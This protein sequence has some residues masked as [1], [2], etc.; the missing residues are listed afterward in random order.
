MFNFFGKGKDDRRG[1]HA[2]SQAPP[3][4]ARNSG[5]VFDVHRLYEEALGN[6]DLQDFETPRPVGLPYEEGGLGGFNDGGPG[7]AQP[8]PLQHQPS[9][10]GAMYPVS[11]RF[12]EFGEKM[13]ARGQSRKSVAMVPSDGLP[14]DRPRKSVVGFQFHTGGGEEGRRSSSKRQSLRRMGSSMGVASGTH[15][16]PAIPFAP[17]RPALSNP[18]LRLDLSRVTGSNPSTSTTNLAPPSP[19]EP[20]ASSSSGYPLATMGPP[21]EPEFDYQQMSDDPFE[22]AYYAEGG[23]ASHHPGA[24]AGGGRETARGDKDKKRGSL[25]KKKKK[26]YLYCSQKTDPTERYSSFGA[27]RDL[28]RVVVPNVLGL[29]LGVLPMLMN[30]VGVWIVGGAWDVSI[31][32]LSTVIANVCLQAPTVGMAASLG[33]LVPQAL[34]AHSLPLCALWLRR[35]LLLLLVLFLPLSICTLK[36]GALVESRLSSGVPVSLVCLRWLIPACL[37]T[38]AADAI[39]GAT[40]AVGAAGPGLLGSLVAAVAHGG[41]LFAFL[42]G[43]AGKHVVEDPSARGAAATAA[44]VATFV[45]S[46]FQLLLLVLLSR[47]STRARAVVWGKRDETS[48]LSRD[49]LRKWG[50][51]IRVGLPLALT[52]VVECL[53]FELQTLEVLWL[54]HSGEAAEEVLL[55]TALRCCFFALHVVP[56]GL[57]LATSTLA[58]SAVGFGDGVLARV[59]VKVA[60]TMI[61]G[62][63]VCAS[64]V[65]MIFGFPLL[66]LLGAHEALRGHYALPAFALFEVVCAVTVIQQSALRAAGRIH[67][68]MAGTVLGFYLCTQPL[69]FV[70]GLACGFPGTAAVWWATLA[71]ACV[72]FGFYLLMLQRLDW[73]ACADAA[74]EEVQQ[75]RQLAAAEEEEREKEAAERQKQGADATAAANGG[76]RKPTAASAAGLTSHREPLLSEDID[77]RPPTARTNQLQKRQT[78]AFEEMVGVEEEDED[79]ESEEGAGGGEEGPFSFRPPN[80]YAL[81]LHSPRVTGTPSPRFR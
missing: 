69:V 47:W 78:Q 73:N 22:H 28:V 23:G 35:T 71:G 13:R 17:V 59:Y 16:T 42:T 20:P 33:V 56:V 41:I 60:L 50:S 40:Q 51:V 48:W 66:K 64:V 14:E 45:S 72:Q 15:Y 11:P 9:D 2:G 54:A 10:L 81:S 75:E 36:L 43:A 12:P 5:D 46:W 19:G 24:G 79:E 38:A 32:T 21:A 57:G 62:L 58:G 27:L 18:A 61:A 8:G 74:V 3:G 29:F 25:A 6:T 55:Q 39:R 76:E 67:L 63:F 44:G 31:L 70:F 49:V 65:L 80:P 52:C 1:S 30:A 68:L 53:A 7:N 77:F 37:A 34:G 26:K 4:S